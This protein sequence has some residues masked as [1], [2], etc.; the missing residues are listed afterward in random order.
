MIVFDNR[1]EIDLKD[2]AG[3]FQR[4]FRAHRLL[5]FVKKNAFVRGNFNH[6]TFHLVRRQSPATLTYGLPLLLKILP[7]K[8]KTV[9]F[10]KHDISLKMFIFMACLV[11]KQIA[12]CKESND[13]RI[14]VIPLNKMKLI[15][16]PFGKKHFYSQLLGAALIYLLLVASLPLLLLSPTSLRQKNTI[17]KAIKYNLS[18]GPTADNPW[19]WMWLQFCILLG[20]INKHENAKKDPAKILV[21]RIDHLG[22]NIN[23]VPL[24]RCLRKKYPC[25]K[26]SVL[27]DTGKFL[28][29]NCP[30]ID[31]VISYNT[32]NTLFSRGKWRLR[33]IFSPLKWLLRL[34]RENYDLVLDPV[35]RT[36]THILS[37]FCTNSLRISNTYYPYRLVGIKVACKHYESNL[38]ETKRVLSLVKAANEITDEE[39]NLEIWFDS[40]AEECAENHLQ[41]VGITE[42]NRILGI[43][44]GAGSPLRLWPI[45][46]FAA[47]SCELA[48]KYNMQILFFE[49]PGRADMTNK[50]SDTI[51]KC[52]RKALIIKDIDLLSLAALISKCDVFLCND[53]G[54]MHLAAATKTPTV[55]IFGPGEYTRWQPLHRKSAIVRKYLNCSPCSQNNCRHPKCILQVQPED[56]LRAAVAVIDKA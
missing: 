22:D 41:A 52:G 9:L 24:I 7:L 46:R 16:K 11:N 18:H 2:V 5:Y 1:D 15:C 33:Y 23:S 12:F 47:V 40:R 39:C 37:L 49:P 34:R 53:S 51:A 29:E 17:F 43:H 42:Q 21:I 13:G 30:Y 31:E 50:F 3:R 26:I 25:A 14:S 56:V 35:G 8:D 28:W 10:R 19:L 54:P 20:N 4:S 55:A 27:T 48:E 45:E 6:K 36:E 44:A 32:N 38:H